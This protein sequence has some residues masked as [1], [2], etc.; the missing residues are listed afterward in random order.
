[1][2]RLEN[3][4]E[5]LRVTASQVKHNYIFNTVKF[6]ELRV[7]MFV[8]VFSY[9]S[10]SWHTPRFLFIVHGLSYRSGSQPGWGTRAVSKGY[11]KVNFS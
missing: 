7:Q 8:Q 10:V 1:M 5:K 11:A 2:T 9:N 3:G 4:L 6:F